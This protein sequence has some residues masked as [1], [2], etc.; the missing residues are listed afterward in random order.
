MMDT[1]GVPLTDSRLVHISNRF[2]LGVIAVCME[3]RS[4]RLPTQ[5][6][7]G[8]ELLLS[9]VFL[10]ASVGV[11]LGVQILT[12]VGLTL[13]SLFVGRHGAVSLHG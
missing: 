6:P 3:F 10:V 8:L 5:A 2:A 12:N 1:D 4:E 7:I 9:F 13:L 11:V